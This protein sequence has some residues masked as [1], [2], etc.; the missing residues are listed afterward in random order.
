[1]LIDLLVFSED[2]KSANKQPTVI[3]ANV[4]CKPVDPFSELSPSFLLNWSSNYSRCN[5]IYNHENDRYYF[6]EKILI[7]GREIRLA[8][9]LDPYNSFE[10]NDVSAMIIRSESV[11]TNYVPDNKFPIDPNRCFLTGVLFPQQPLQSQLTETDNYL[12]TVNG[13]GT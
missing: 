4:D 13:G 6:A 12:I 5:Y 2:P 11:G 1:M 8:C 10:L 9:K 3:A 7:T